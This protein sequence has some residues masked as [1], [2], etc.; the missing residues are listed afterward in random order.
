MAE[1]KLEKELIEKLADIEHQRWS[2]WQSYL[3][4]KCLKHTIN[5]YNSA[6]R[7][8]E[9]IETGAMVIPKVLFENWARQINTPY[10][11]L[12]EKEK[13][14]DREQVDRYFPII[15]DL[16]SK[17]R[18][19][20]TK[21]EKKKLDNFI[22]GLET[23]IKGQAIQIKS[24]LKQEEEKQNP[25]GK[26]IQEYRDKIESLKKLSAAVYSKGVVK[27]ETNNT[28]DIKLSGADLK[29]IAETEQIILQMKSDVVKLEEEM[30]EEEELRD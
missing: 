2:E 14:S 9:E 27:N 1:T 21:E 12:S 10:K 15:K 11:D 16:I 4:S 26:L 28:I 23:T 17:E 3:H 18:E 19:E 13:D 5:S 25:K 29:N 6:K 30:L 20:A 7:R 22:L 24:F 8:Y